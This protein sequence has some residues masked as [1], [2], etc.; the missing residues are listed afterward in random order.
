M[1]SHVGG[2][3]GLADNRGYKY[4]SCTIQDASNLSSATKCCL[5]SK[6]AE[7]QPLLYESWSKRQHTVGPHRCTYAIGNREKQTDDGKPFQ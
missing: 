3:S 2:S 1:V 7:I 5:F 6:S 4:F